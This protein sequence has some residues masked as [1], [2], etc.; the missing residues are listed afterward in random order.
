[1]FTHRKRF[2]ILALITVV[3]AFSTGDRATLSVAGSGMAKELQLSPVQMGWLFSSFAWAYVLAHIPAGWLVDRLGAKRTVVIG[4]VLWSI[5]TALQGAAAWFGSVFATLIALRFLMGVFEAPVGPA[6]GRVIAMWFPSG[7]RGVAG[8]IFNSAQYLSLAVFTPLMGWL[9][10]RF[11]WEHVFSVMGGLG[12]LLAVVWYAWFHVPATHPSLSAQE[13]DS[14]RAGGALTD[15]NARQTSV[16]KDPDAPGIL[17]LFRSRML[18]G[19]FLAQYCIT[20]I[21]WFFVS[22]F[23]TYLVKER[24]F[25]ILNAGFIASLPAIAGFI[26]GVSTGF[27]TDWLLRRTGSL[28]IARKIP[29][30]IGLLLTASMIGCNF[31]DA[32]WMVIGLMSLA[33]F[34]KGFGS[35]GWTVVADTAPKELIGLT[36]GVFNAIGNTAGITTPL[37]IGYILGATNSFHYALVFVGLHGLVAVMSYWLIVGKIERFNVRSRRRSG[38]ANEVIDGTPAVR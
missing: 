31:V 26:G 3:L 17:D 27:V 25:S 15:L 20:A 14:I 16:R 10:H 8:A 12:L 34:G 11:G 23:P 36:G 35:L 19:I 9:D 18:S 24:G 38:N 22:W 6:S 33:F 7:E 5:C 13:L 21:T 37:V 28:T 30:T 1:M 2:L 4:L 29:I 32:D